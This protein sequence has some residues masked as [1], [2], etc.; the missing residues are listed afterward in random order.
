MVKEQTE[1]SKSKVPLYV[2]AY[3]TLYS[4]MADGHY[5]PGDKLP[6]ENELAKM[7]NISRGTL[8]QALLLFQEDGLIINKHGSGNY[9]TEKIAKTSEGLEK[10]TVICDRFSREK[11]KWTLTNIS[12]QPATKI[13]SETLRIDNEKLVVLFELIYCVDDKKISCMDIFLPYDILQYENI[14]LNNYDDM[15]TFIF[16][17]I[18][19]K[20]NESYVDLRVIDVRS[21]IAKRLE[22]TEGSSLCCFYEVMYTEMGIPTVYTKS[23]CVPSEYNFYIHSKR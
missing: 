6:N 7:L 2:S 22:I 12:Y 3:E 10:K 16:N 23:Y 17:Y 8:R 4:L 14:S 5:L 20:T 15:Q 9:V 18:A 19:Q 21:R 11:G 1:V 13:I